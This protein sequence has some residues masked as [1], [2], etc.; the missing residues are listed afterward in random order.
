MM[1]WR[2]Y[3]RDTGNGITSLGDDVVHLETGQLSALTRLRTLCHLY[4]YLLGIDEILC[5]N[6]K[7]SAGNLFCLAAE[8]H[9]IHLCMIAGIILTTLTGVGACAYLIHRQSQGLMGLYA[10]GTE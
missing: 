3:Q 8:T 1:R 9:A 6:A 2:R 5:R 4:L 10:Q 7:A